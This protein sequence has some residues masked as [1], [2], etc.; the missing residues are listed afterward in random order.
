MIDLLRFMV[1]AMKRLSRGALC[2]FRLPYRTIP[3]AVASTG[4]SMQG[5]SLYLYATATS[6]TVCVSRGS[7][8]IPNRNGMTT[9]ALIATRALA[10]LGI[11][12]R[13]VVRPVPIGCQEFVGLRDS[14]PSFFLGI[15]ATNPNIVV[16]LRTVA[17]LLLHGMSF[18]PLPPAQEDAP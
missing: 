13:A 10:L 3:Y 8:E 7:S 18:V 11:A 16:G 5:V 6:D 2:T 4:T 1:F 9:D 17:S 14:D 15:E 12:P